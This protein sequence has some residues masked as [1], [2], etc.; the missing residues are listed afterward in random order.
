MS[1]N[2]ETK[3]KIMKNMMKMEDEPLNIKNTLIIILKQFC[4]FYTFM[5]FLYY[6]FENFKT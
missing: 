2:N 6:L 1:Q 4:Y 3:A 5:S